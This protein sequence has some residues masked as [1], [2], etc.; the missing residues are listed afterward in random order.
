MFID[1]CLLRVASLPWICQLLEAKIGILDTFVRQGGR[2]V[3]G[4]YPGGA[5]SIPV[6]RTSFFGGCFE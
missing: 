4:Y 3:L 6:G 5:G 2:R 1:F